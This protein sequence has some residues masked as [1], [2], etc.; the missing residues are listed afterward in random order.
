MLLAT[1]HHCNVKKLQSIS[2]IKEL[3]LFAINIL[4]QRNNQHHAVNDHSSTVP[5]L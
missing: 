1:E 3:Q 5:V 2:F 4:H